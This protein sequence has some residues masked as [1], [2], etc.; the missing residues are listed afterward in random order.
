MTPLT[1]IGECLI[2]TKKR[3]YLF[4]PSFAAMTR[5][6]SPA[7]IVQAFYDVH[8]DSGERVIYSEL[9]R[10]LFGNSAF[11]GLYK[12]ISGKNDNPLW[13]LDRIHQVRRKSFMAAVSVIQ[14]C[15]D[16]D[17]SELT[18]E[19]VPSRSRTGSLVWRSGSLSFEKILLVA[20]SLIT[21]GVIGKAKTRQL[22][23]N[24]GKEAS[25][26]FFAIEYINSARTH[27]GMT[28]EE[29]ER[30]TM[31]EFTMLINAK[32]PPEKGFTRDEY[33]AV[34][35]EDDRKWQEMIDKQNR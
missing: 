23:R 15:C 35:D 3:D 18:G 31:T 32:Y 14:A 22:Q 21:H 30:L 26:E 9:S 8:D 33:D 10:Q 4:R 27:F 16:D 17:C 13:I 20:Q 28:R 7:E 34:M 29:A 25:T 19:L 6:G 12:E 2:S 5:I 1:E 11:S 24:E